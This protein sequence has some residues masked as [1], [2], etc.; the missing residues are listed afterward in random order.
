MISLSLQGPMYFPGV[1]NLPTLS[2]TTGLTLNW[3]VLIAWSL[4]HGGTMTLPGIT[5]YLSTAVWS[6]IYD[7]IYSHQVA[8]AMVVA[9]LIV[10]YIPVVSCVPR[11][12]SFLLIHTVFSVKQFYM[13]PNVSNSTTCQLV[14]CSSLIENTA[15][16]MC[17]LKSLYDII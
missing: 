8:I 13:A 5:L 3:G 10:I 7:S 15:L 16:C 14:P 1:T 17:L 9:V 2:V 12:A 11:C 4:E 6:I